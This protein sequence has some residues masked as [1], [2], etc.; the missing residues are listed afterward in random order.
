[1]GVRGDGVTDGAT[2]TG[3]GRRKRGRG[4]GGG[5]GTGGMGD[6]TVTGIPGGRGL[7]GREGDARNGVGEEGGRAGRP[8]REM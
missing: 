3:G 5:G 8:T 6:L 4:R 7:S 1:M 2:E